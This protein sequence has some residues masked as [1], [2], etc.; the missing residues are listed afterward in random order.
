MKSSNPKLLKDLI[1]KKNAILILENG[2]FYWGNGIGAKGS[3][4]GELCFKMEN[5]IRYV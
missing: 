2:D 5:I 4:I 1:H 3:T